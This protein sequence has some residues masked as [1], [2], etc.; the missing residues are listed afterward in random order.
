MAQFLSKP[1]PPPALYK[2]RGDIARDVKCLL[3]DRCLYLASPLKLNDPFDC[4]PAIAVP[5]TEDHE[6]I[7]ASEVANV[8]PGHTEADIRERCRLILTSEVH[9]RRFAKE[10]YE[11][12]LGRVGVLSLSAPRDEPLLWAHYARNGAGFFVGYRGRD[13][14]EL[15]ALGVA[16]VLYSVQRPAMNVFDDEKNWFKILH[17]KSEHWSYEEEWRYVRTA[18]EGGS[19]LMTVPPNSIVEVCLGPRMTGDERKAVIN[20]ARALPDNPRIFQVEL[21]HDCYGLRFIEFGRF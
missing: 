8:P 2:Y 15:E 12:D 3:I 1:A 10:F 19:G 14:G 7:I 4:S 5:P 9:R 11:K 13:D 18:E 17:T 21:D 20:A 16:P 6:R